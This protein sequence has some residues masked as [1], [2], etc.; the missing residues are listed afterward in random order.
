MTIM[1]F[2]FRVPKIAVLRLLMMAFAAGITVELSSCDLSS[3]PDGNSNF[4]KN[5]VKSY[6]LKRA[7]DNKVPVIIED[8]SN[9]QK[10]I[11]HGETVLTAVCSVKGNGMAQHF[12]I[13]FATNGSGRY[14]SGGEDLLKEIDNDGYQAVSDR[15]AMQTTGESKDR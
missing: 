10:M 6:M 9:T 13:Y 7:A 4:N 15:I 3:D 14:L 11:L 5:L 2:C 8:V 12:L 1:V